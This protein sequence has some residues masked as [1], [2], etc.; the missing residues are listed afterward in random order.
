[1]L[2]KREEHEKI[3]AELVVGM[4]NMLPLVDAVKDRAKIMKL[5]MTIIEILRL[6]ED[7]SRFVVEYMSRSQSGKSRSGTNNVLYNYTLTRI[8]II[9]RAVRALVYSTSNEVENILARFKDLKEDFDRGMAVQ[10]VQGVE[11]LLNNGKCYSQYGYTRTDC[12][13]TSQLTVS[14]SPHL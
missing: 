5:E 6:I 3:V 8:F 13:P 10:V 2:E 7:T 11:V 9:A 4:G 14:C 12:K 1:M